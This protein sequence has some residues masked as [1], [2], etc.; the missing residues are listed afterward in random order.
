[1]LNIAKALDARADINAVRLPTPCETPL[2]VA[3]TTLQCCSA[4]KL[5]L[6]YENVNLYVR[7]G[8]GRNLLHRAV[9][10]GCEICIQSLLDVGLSMTDEDRFGFS[11]FDLA[12]ENCLDPQPLAT[13]LKHAKNPNV[14]TRNGVEVNIVEGLGSDALFRACS[15]RPI[16]RQ[17]VEL[18]LLSGWSL[19]TK[20]G[21]TSPIFHRNLEEEHWLLSEMIKYPQIILQIDAR[22]PL[23]HRAGINY[24]CLETEIRE[25]CNS[26]AM[27]PVVGVHKGRRRSDCVER[28][29]PGLSHPRANAGATASTASF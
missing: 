13:L 25:S 16:R 22:D 10:L 12:V 9:R 2:Q 3:T 28:P 26:A 6:K 24:R 27:L 18:L 1:M 29:N 20:T 11:A 19:M 14:V 8:E 15:I 23:C 5:L 21:A 17:H 4:L 7:D